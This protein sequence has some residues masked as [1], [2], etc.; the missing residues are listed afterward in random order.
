MEAVSQGGEP[1]LNDQLKVLEL[2]EEGF[3]FQRDWW[4][5]LVM[6][7]GGSLALFVLV[8]VTRLVVRLVLCI[9]CLVV[10]F[11]G[12][13]AFGPFIGSFLEPRLPE[14][15]L[16][17]MSAS[18]YGYVAAFLLCYAVALGIGGLLFRPLK[19]CKSQVKK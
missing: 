13:V 10:A 1:S 5:Y 15:A 6:L 2:D 17:F 3:N 11:F 14:A 16:Q 9:A 8:R 7:V 18:N 12:A 4:K 19:N